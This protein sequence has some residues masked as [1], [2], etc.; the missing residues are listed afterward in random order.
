MD[1]V[2]LH[3][4]VFADIDEYIL[5][6]FFKDHGF[7]VEIKYISSDFGVIQLETDCAI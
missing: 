7:L 1:D 6:L 2:D 3:L 5:L 4:L